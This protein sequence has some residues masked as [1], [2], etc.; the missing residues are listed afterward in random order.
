MATIKEIATKAGVSSATVSRVLNYDDSLSVSEETKKRIFRAAEQLNYSKNQKKKK[1]NQGSIA[2][3]QW[4]QEQEELNESY[5]V[6]IR[7]GIENKAQEAGYEV[8]RYVQEPRLELDD[9]ILG[10]I[11]L[12]K[13]SDAEIETLQSRTNQICFVDSNHIL[14]K[15]D[16]V[17]I[18]IEQAVAEVVDYVI[19]EKHTKIGCIGGQEWYTDHSSKILDKRP[20]IFAQLLKDHHLYQKKYFFTAES[21]HVE[22]GEKITQ[23]AID[24]LGEDFP[25]VIFVS[26]DALAIGC[27]RTLQENGSAVPEDV[28]IIGFN[29]ASVA[30]Y[31]FPTLSTVRVETELMGQTAFDLLMN[32][33]ESERTTAIKVSLS[34]DLIIRESSNRIGASK[35]L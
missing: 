25:S 9:D 22:D 30:K 23:Q 28:C 1:S 31:I 35:N 18:D 29:D 24:Q 19:E 26:N 4:T 33:I 17:G 14:G 12:G 20:L 10:I 8:K 13:F 7:D 6:S 21:N 34:T 11:A 3:V 32:R 15:F 5:Y 27:L 2:I 16:S